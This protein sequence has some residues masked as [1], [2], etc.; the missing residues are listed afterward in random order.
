[1][2]DLESG[3]LLDQYRVTGVL[4]RGGMATLYTAEDTLGAGE[5]VL[6]VPHP[7]YECDV[8]FYQR[9]ERE[10]RIGQQIA[11]PA[12][13]KVLTP[14]EKSRLYLAMERVP[15]VPLHQ[16]L[17]AES[18][19]PPE[20]ALAIARQL[21][22][23]LSCLQEHGVVHRDV[24]P[25]NVLVAPDGS[26]KLLDFGIALIEAAR[27][28]T[29]AGLS[30]ALGTP[31]YMAPEQI[32]GRRG[33]ARTDVYALGTL[34]HEM[35]AGCLPYDTSSVTALLHAKQHADP[36][37]LSAHRPGLDPALERIVLRA[38]ARDPRDRYPTAAA[39]LA[40][41]EAPGAAVLPPPPTPQVTPGRRARRALVVAL[42]AGAAV[43]G[44]GALARHGAERA[45]AA[46]AAR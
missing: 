35:L 15:G 16:V 38:I 2:D 44:L 20:R 8:V 41:L 39:L 5:V 34:L 40:D 36:P 46:A 6:K 24:K 31:D 30:H 3:A 19:L 22:S 11:H 43:A 25:E 12:I 17:A 33:D 29:W 28:L 27:R 14:R 18:P 9:F 4:A 23:A 37:P 26:V 45:P 10:E 1:M 32:R 42:V 21:C 7:Q 13:V